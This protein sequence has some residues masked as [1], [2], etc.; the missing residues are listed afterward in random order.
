MNGPCH[1]GFS[2]P[3]FACEQHGKVAWC[4]ALQERKNFPHFVAVTH[5]KS[6][7]I[8]V[9][10]LNGRFCVAFAQN[11]TRIAHLEMLFGLEQ[12]MVDPHTIELQSV[13]A[14]QIA[15]TK[16]FFGPRQFTMMAAGTHIPHKRNITPL[17]ASDVIPLARKQKRL[18]FVGS[19]KRGKNTSV[20]M[21]GR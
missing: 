6:R 11:K 19:L 1:T 20:C 18:A 7:L 21:D 3:C 10:H 13:S 14:T 17:G 15:Y 9:E 4:N 2:R 12:R 16:T 8:V 5:E